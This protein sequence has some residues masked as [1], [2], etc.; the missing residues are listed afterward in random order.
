[1]T[2]NSDDMYLD[3]IGG[4]HQSATL[5]PP[6]SSGEK[7]QS[8]KDVLPRPSCQ[9]DSMAFSDFGNANEADQSPIEDSPTA[10]E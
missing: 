6:A 9:P 3:T 8:S 7:D 4:S 2:H 1:M 10:V 5:Q